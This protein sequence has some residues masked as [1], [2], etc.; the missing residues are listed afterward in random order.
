MADASL[1][2]RMTVRLGDAAAFAQFGIVGFDGQVELEALR[3]FGLPE[4]AP[5][6]LLPA[7][8]PAPHHRRRRAPQIS[9]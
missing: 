8:P 2:R 9:L 7:R 4:A 3:L 5:A 6:R 1:N